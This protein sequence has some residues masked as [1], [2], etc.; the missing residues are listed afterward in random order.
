MSYLNSPGYYMQREL[1]ERDLAARA[2]SIRIETIHAHLA[3]CYADL[4]RAAEK[5]P[6]WGQCRPGRRGFHF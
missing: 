5:V 3:R 6:G 4:A 2:D 1:H